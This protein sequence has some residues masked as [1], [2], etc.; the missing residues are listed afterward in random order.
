MTYLI[1]N[2]FR[3]ITWRNQLHPTIGE[4]NSEV[5][6]APPPSRITTMN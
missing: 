6:S 3:K 2:K 4:I 5:C 1:E